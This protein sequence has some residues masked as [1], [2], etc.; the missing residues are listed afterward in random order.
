MKHLLLLGLFFISGQIIAQNDQ[1]WNL[2]MVN[3]QPGKITS[4]LKPLMDYLD[5][6]GLRSGKIIVAASI[7]EMTNLFTNGQIDFMFESPYGALQ[8]MDATKAVPILIREKKGVREYNS[9]IFV[10]NNSTI[11]QLSDLP[12]KVIAFEDKT[13]TSSY[14]LPFQLLKQNGLKLIQSGTPINGAVAYYF[15]GADNNTLLQ[16]KKG[17]LADVGGIKKYKLKNLKGFRILKP[18]SNFVPRHIVLIRKGRDYQKLKSILLGMKHD[19]TAQKALKKAKTPTGFSEFDGVP[20]IIMNTT[21][22]KS[23]GL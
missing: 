21:V 19:K 13:S 20:N 5:R 22:R 18:E 15:S 9:V 14:I 7:E 3:A 1:V 12:G 10:R 6:Q 4:R 17:T 11:Q 16:V 8:I 23:L 2:G